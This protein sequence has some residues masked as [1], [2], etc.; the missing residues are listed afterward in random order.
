[1]EFHLLMQNNDLIV[2]KE[3][4]IIRAAK[5]LEP[6]NKPSDAVFYMQLEIE[7]SYDDISSNAPSFGTSDPYLGIC[8]ILGTTDFFQIDGDSSWYSCKA[9]VKVTVIN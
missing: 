6:G 9:V 3:S 1:M 2:F 5:A 7:N 8:G 4:T